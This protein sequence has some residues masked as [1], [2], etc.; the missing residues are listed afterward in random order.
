MYKDIG[1]FKQV[2]HAIRVEMGKLVRLVKKETNQII[3][4]IEDCHSSPVMDMY[5][6]VRGK[7]KISKYIPEDQSKVSLVTT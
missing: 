3:Y 1:I 4:T 5:L 2:P 7:V 6:I